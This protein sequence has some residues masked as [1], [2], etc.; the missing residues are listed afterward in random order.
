MSGRKG[1]QSLKVLKASQLKITPNELEAICRF[2]KLGVESPE[3]QEFVE[4]QV[5]GQGKTVN[6]AIADAQAAREQMSS[7]FQS[8]PESAPNFTEDQFSDQSSGAQH[9]AQHQGF[10]LNELLAQD[11]ATSSDALADLS[12]RMQRSS[13]HKQAVGRVLLAQ[14]EEAIAFRLTQLIDQSA[15]LALQLAQNGQNLD[16]LWNALDQDPT[17]VELD[18]QLKAE[19]RSAVQVKSVFLHQ[20]IASPCASSIGSDPW[21]LRF[22]PAPKVQVASLPPASHGQN[23]LDSAS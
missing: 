9:Q 4:K 3:V 7:T 12:R 23:L 6:N 2:L 10:S 21:R 18:E 14:Q 15:A 22:A 5:K 13:L 20:Q 1:M 19:I 8:G 16:A 17:Y 11:Q